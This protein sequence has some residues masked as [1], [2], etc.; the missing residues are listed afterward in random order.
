MNPCASL[1]SP[2]PVARIVAYW[3][4]AVAI[5]AGYF[6]FLA[7]FSPLVLER[8]RDTSAWHAFSLAEE[9]WRQYN[10]LGSDSPAGERLRLLKSA[11][12]HSRRAYELRPDSRHYLWT[13]AWSLYSLANAQS[14]ADRAKIEE[15]RGLARKAWEMSGKTFYNPGS[16]LASEYIRDGSL[17]E[18][19]LLLEDLIAL[20]PARAG[21]HDSLMEIAL[22]KGNLQEAISILE[23]KGVA[24]NLEAVEREF[25]GVLC[26]KVGD[27]PKAERA[28]ASLVQGGAATRD[29]WFLYGL[30]LLG[31]GKT[32]E[33]IQV[34]RT[35]RAAQGEGASW[36]TPAEV[37]LEQFPKEVEATLGASLKAAERDSQ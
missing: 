7:W 26:L 24:L 15:A 10:S 25:L 1:P 29:R 5:A 20:D 9:A 37:G 33:A 2:L 36:P 23:R 27:F 11:E 18:A 17:E 19:N 22:R 34:L 4:G 32:S 21:A 35:V 28:L 31:E 13:W 14:P 6:A 16:F 3:V 30:A 8:D 12:E